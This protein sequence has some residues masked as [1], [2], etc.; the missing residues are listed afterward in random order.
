MVTKIAKSG[1]ANE[2]DAHNLLINRRVEGTYV[3]YNRIVCFKIVLRIYYS[4][5][6]LCETIVMISY[7][8]TYAHTHTHINSYVRLNCLYKLSFFNDYE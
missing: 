2:F 7:L 8:G 3:N 5:N 1:G 6:S 4:D